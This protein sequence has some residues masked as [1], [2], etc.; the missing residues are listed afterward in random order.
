M[1]SKSCTDITYRSTD[2]ESL[3]SKSEASLV[4]KGGSYNDSTPTLHRRNASSSDGKGQGTMSSF[5]DDNLD[6]FSQGE[7]A[8]NVVLYLQ[9]NWWY[10]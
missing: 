1:E 3:K 9:S 8:T 2:E 6:E 10:S 7:H 4:M 5:V